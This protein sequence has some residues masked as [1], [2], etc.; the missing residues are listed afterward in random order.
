MEK[1][2]EMAQKRLD[3]KKV[4]DPSKRSFYEDGFNDGYHAGYLEASAKMLEMVEQ[5]RGR[6][7]AQFPD[8]EVRPF[9][10]AETR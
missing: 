8:A 10:K 6:K 9:D 4:K 2:I 5:I 7:K 3:R 1:I